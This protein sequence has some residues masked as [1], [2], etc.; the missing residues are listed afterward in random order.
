MDLSSFFD[1]PDVKVHEAADELAF[2][3]DRSERDW[4][5]VLAHTDA[6]PFGAGDTVIRTGDVDRALYIVTSG[7]LAMVLP[8]GDGG[9]KDFKAIE[10][11]TVL[12]EVNFV[13][14]G[15]RSTTIRAVSDGEMR[16]LSYEAFEVLAARE[17]ELGRAIL[18]D[19]A[20]ILA[21]RLRIATDFIADWVA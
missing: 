19:I 16:R 5:K 15:V 9:D 13:S 14:G 8:H 17:P 20:R 12:G 6:R 3:A 21:H 2:L 1:Y 11:P 10:A 4:E 7:V 18:L